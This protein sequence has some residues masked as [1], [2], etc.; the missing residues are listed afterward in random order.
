MYPYGCKI[1][2]SPTTENLILS[3]TIMRKI[4][5]AFATTLCA[6]AGFVQAASVESDTY[7]VISMPAKAGYNLFSASVCP[8]D[9]T[10]SDVFGVSDTMSFEASET[11]ISSENVATSAD[12]L[13]VTL[14]DTF[15]YNNQGAE[16]TIYQYGIDPSGSASF[17]A[18]LTGGYDTIG[19]PFAT[20]RKLGTLGGFQDAGFRVASK[21]GN[22]IYLW[23]PELQDYDFYFL[24]T[25]GHWY[26]RNGKDIM[27]NV[28]LNPGQGFMVRKGTKSASEGITF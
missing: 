22:T 2:F 18:A 24:K 3:K 17:V 25:D 9:G 27:D 16:T 15:W 26:L 11:I 28:V 4:T 23:N 8:V 13:N 10:I 19:V 7:A 14:G 21:Y 12:Q 20:T 1:D 6:L 5:L